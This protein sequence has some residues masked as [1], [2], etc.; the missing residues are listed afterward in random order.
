MNPT[1]DI[2]GHGWDIFADT[3]G[4]HFRAGFAGDGTGSIMDI[5]SDDVPVVACK[6]YDIMASFRDRGSPNPIGVTFCVN[7]I[8]VTGNLN[9]GADVLCE[10]QTNAQFG[11][12]FGGD[13]VV[14]R[15]YRHMIVS[16]GFNSDTDL[17][18]SLVDATVITDGGVNVLLVNSGSDPGYGEKDISWTIQCLGCGVTTGACCDAMGG[19]TTTTLADCTG[20]YLGDGTVCSPN[21]CGGVGTLPCCFGT[22]S[23]PH[24][25]AT[26]SDLSYSNCIA[27]G[28]APLS[29]TGHCSDYYPC[30]IMPTCPCETYTSVTGCSFVVCC[31][32]CYGDYVSSCSCTAPDA[33]GCSCTEMGNNCD[34]CPGPY[35]DPV[36]L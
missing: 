12:K 35:F 7:G 25:P 19:C 2:A 21:P 5:S 31:D 11:D 27:E 30:Q 32:P 26:C 14:N 29:S 23:P 18:D 16:P 13:A 4:W 22:G 1:P 24:A 17:F 3:T 34:C 8:F 9:R 28:G 36:C 10:T 33:P 6:C 15:K 20:T